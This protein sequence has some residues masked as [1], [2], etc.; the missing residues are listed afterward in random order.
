MFSKECE[1][2]IKASIY[3]AQKSNKNLSVN[4]KEVAKEVNAP[5]AFTSKILQKLCK[6]NILRSIRGKQGGFIF[7]GEMQHQIKLFD[8]IKIID[9]DAIFSNCG[10]GLHKC[11][12]ENPCPVHDDFKKVRDELISMVQKYSFYELAEKTNDGLAWLK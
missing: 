8:V 4:A 12:A 5:E 11:S 6:E 3:I 2:A 9:G 7:E 1:Y 10:L